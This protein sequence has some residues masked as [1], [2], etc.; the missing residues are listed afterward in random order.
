MINVTYKASGAPLRATEAEMKDA[1]FEESKT[2]A[3]RMSE[4]Y[5]NNLKITLL[6][7]KAFA[8]GDTMRSVKADSIYASSSRDRV[9]SRVTASRSIIFIQGGRKP[10]KAPLKY[11]GT[12]NGRKQFEP[13]PSMVKWFL[14]LGIPKTAWNW[15]CILIGK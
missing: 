6:R 4:S 3:Q 7:V 14:A 5:A 9:S 15:I 10:R 2:L 13:L 11:L 12:V 1:I 8:T